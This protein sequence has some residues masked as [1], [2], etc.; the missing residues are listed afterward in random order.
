MKDV[1][2]HVAPPDEAGLAG[3]QACETEDDGALEE[4]MGVERPRGLG[5]HSA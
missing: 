1:V 2:G 5:I 4:L 3:A